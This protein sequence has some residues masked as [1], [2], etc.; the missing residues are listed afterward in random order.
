ME[1]LRDRQRTGR[2][3]QGTDRHA[4]WTRAIVIDQDP[5]QGQFGI[6]LSV[7]TVR[8]VL[9]RLRLTPQRP[10]RCATQYEPADVQRWKDPEFLKTLRRARE[11]GA[12]LVCADESGLAAQSMHGRTWGLCGQTPVGRV[13]SERFRLHR[14]AASSPEGQL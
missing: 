1:N 3:R 9:R 14:L 4:A 8:R 7:S 2:P 6:V 11:L 5:A 12:L 13:A 10:Q